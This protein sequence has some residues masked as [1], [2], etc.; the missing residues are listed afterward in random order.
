VFAVAPTAHFCMGGIVTDPDGQTA[1]PGL[2]AAGE[3][4]AGVHGANRLGGNAL[5]EIFTMGAV[6]GRKAAELAGTL[7]SPAV[8]GEAVSEEKNRLIQ[9]F[10]TDGER[11]RRLI[12]DLQALMWKR[13]GIIRR[14]EELAAA[15]R[16][17]E[18]TWPEMAVC[19]PGDLIRRLEFENMRLVARLVCRAALERTE[20]RGSHFREDH[21]TE[22]NSDWLQNIIQTK[23]AGEVA[24]H[25]R[26]AVGDEAVTGERDAG[27][28]R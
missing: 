1:L 9:L 27:S 13:V 17:I 25:L 8:A 28:G 12:Q 3:A 19:S 5:A 24:S 15:L 26:K 18:G 11:P 22:N 10:Q 2:F 16:Q 23:A 21:P 20:S 6:A 14:A 7:A 4:A